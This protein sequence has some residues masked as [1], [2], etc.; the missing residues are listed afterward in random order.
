MSLI[1]TIARVVGTVLAFPYLTGYALCRMTLGSERAFL[2]ISERIAK[3]PGVSGI[4]VRQACY[5]RL[6]DHVG[7][8]VHFGYLSIISKPHTVIGERVYIG[9]LCVIGYAQVGDEVMVADGVHILSGRHQHGVESVDGRSLRAN[10]QRFEKVII[11]KGAWLC[12]GA[13][14]MADVGE[15]AVVGAG[16]VVVKPVPPG[17]KVGGVPA[18]PLK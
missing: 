13:I 6:L 11:G 18:K 3:L 16:A 2:Y 10:P 4:Y 15:R 5:G 17:G 8:D 12:A 9:R 1:K 7:D 14:V